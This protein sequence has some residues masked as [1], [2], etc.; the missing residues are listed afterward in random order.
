MEPQVCFTCLESGSGVD[1]LGNIVGICPLAPG[2]SADV[3]IWDGHGPSRNRGEFFDFEDGGA[4]CGTGVWCRTFGAVVLMNH[5]SSSVFCCI[6][7]NSASADKCGTPPYGP[8]E[9]VPPH[10]WAEATASG[11]ATADVYNEAADVCALC[12]VLLSQAQH[13]SLWCMVRQRTH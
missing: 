4:A 7:R 12:F 11:A 3:L 13:H 2:T 10:V 8:W 1:V 9:Q 5:I 6:S